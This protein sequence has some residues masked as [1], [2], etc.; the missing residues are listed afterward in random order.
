VQFTPAPLPVG[1]IVNK[2]TRY[3]RT[4][5]NRTQLSPSRCLPKEKFTILHS[6]EKNQK[7]SMDAL[8][9]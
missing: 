9:E 5:N 8:F 3:F 7:N 1:S 2:T 6:A 4:I